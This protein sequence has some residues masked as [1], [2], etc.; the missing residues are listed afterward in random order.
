MFWLNEI[1][2][3][4]PQRIGSGQLPDFGRATDS[5]FPA[6]DVT[7]NK[8]PAN[9]D[10]R[11][12]ARCYDAIRNGAGWEKT[13]FI[14]TYDEH[15]GTWDHVP[16][17]AAV[18]PDNQ[19]HD[20]FAFD[21]YGVRVPA[22]LVSPWIPAGTVVRAPEPGPP[23]DHA[24]ILATLRKIFGPF[25]ALTKRDAAAPD[26]LGALSLQAPTNHGPRSLPLPTPY[27]DAAKIA[28]A[29]EAPA[30][31][32]QNVLAAM[33]ESLPVGIANVNEHATALATTFAKGLAPIERTAAQ[34]L[35]VV[36]KGLTRFLTGGG[37]TGP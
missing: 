30:T 11:L 18:P 5:N 15:G 27:S 31:A 9:I 10:W 33:A 24:S 6:L 22:V 20:G 1:H 25:N 14:I 35:E 8:K 16:P 36:K 28:V 19:R 13:L 21:R 12:I 7:H 2:L 4:D 29:V 23:F 17:P 34:A 3:L 37:S 26:L 32:A